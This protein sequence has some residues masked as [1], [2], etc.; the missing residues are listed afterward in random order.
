MST[1][2]SV[3][4]ICSGVRLDNRYEHSIYFA[5]ATAQEN[6]FAGKVVK[7]FSAYSYLRKSWSVKVEA[8]MEQAKTWNYLYF[9]NTTSG[10]LYYYFINQ[11]EYVN[12][13]TVELF[14]E[15]DV[16]QTYL[17]DFTLLNCFVERQHTTSDE[18]GEHTVD[19]GLEV[20]DYVV[21]SIQNIG[22]SNNDLC[23]LVMTTVTLNG[24]SKETT[25]DC[26]SAMY[27]KTYS[28][29]WV[30]AIDADDWA[31]WGRQLE[32]LSEWNKIDGI[33]GMW[34]YPK[35]LLDVD[36]EGDES[37]AKLV[38]IEGGTAPYIAHYVEGEL[39]RIDGYTPKNKK[40]FSYPYAFMYVT[41]NTGES[42]VY[43][44]E[45]FSSSEPTFRIYGAVSPSEGARVVPLNYNGA[46]I[47]YEE[48]LNLSGYPSCAWDCDTYKLWL[49]QNQNQQKLNNFI[50][51]A[52]VVGGII[53]AVAGGPIG[54]IA[55][56]GTVV[57]GATQIAGALAEKK[58]KEF[59]PPQ[60]RG[61]F[62]STINAANGLHAFFLMD[63]TVNK[64]HAKII[65]DYFTMYGYKLNRV[66]KPN[67]NARPAFTYVKT[68][69]CHIQ[70]NVCNEEI[71]KIEGIFDKGITFW[72]N[73]D[74]VADYSQDN[75]V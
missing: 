1:P 52:K 60:A 39:E 16:L 2:Q 73:G 71:V 67:I 4:K 37:L 29:M 69:D 21:N 12:D 6:Y 31:E 74:K 23:I 27:G 14:L 13:L 44:Y 47:N 20:G 59:E 9:R 22:P 54:A 26:Y 40:L 72:K 53:G 28:S 34:M 38:N 65:D 7:T 43:K 63:K 49:A 32:N 58:D 70:G 8:T 45:R 61:T 35:A 56:A 19:E 24:T 17:F 5:S 15:L 42:A 11:I 55:G 33:I 3:I 41:N 25:V 50:G 57:S 64:E 75:T 62:S 48:G 68:I 66:Q 46:S 10:K 51:G 30:Y 36:W 18:R